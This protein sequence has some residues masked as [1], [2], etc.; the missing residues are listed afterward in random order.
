MYCEVGYSQSE[1]LQWITL[2]NCI[3]KGYLRNEMD[4]FHLI[5]IDTQTASSFEE[6][7]VKYLKA[8]YKAVLCLIKSL[9]SHGFTCVKELKVVMTAKNRNYS[10]FSPTPDGTFRLD[11]RF[12]TYITVALVVHKENGGQVFHQ[13][14]SIVHLKT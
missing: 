3:Q 7:W 14:C 1:A 6:G 11:Q 8:F 2:F 13:I 4:V 12:T 10:I 5:F 9:K